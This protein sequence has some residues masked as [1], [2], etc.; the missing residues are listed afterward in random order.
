MLEE[1]IRMARKRGGGAS[2]KAEIFGA[3]IPSPLERKR[4]RKVRKNNKIAAASRRKNR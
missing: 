2:A 3:K 4:K 1:Y